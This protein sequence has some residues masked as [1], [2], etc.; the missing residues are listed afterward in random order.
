MLIT[1]VKL[2]I[3]ILNNTDNSIKKCQ[4][5]IFREHTNDYSIIFTNNDYHVFNYSNF[6]F[7]I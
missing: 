3:T 6:S 1:R 4:E 5:N 7:Y 2:G